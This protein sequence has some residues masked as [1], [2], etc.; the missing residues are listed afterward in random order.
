M[1][2]LD[3][4]PRPAHGQEGGRFAGIALHPRASVGQGHVVAFQGGIIVWMGR[5]AEMPIGTGA[6][7]LCMHPDD[8]AA[9]ATLPTGSE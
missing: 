3:T 9:I 2:D 4:Y 6:T 7:D 5:L 1:A 8:I